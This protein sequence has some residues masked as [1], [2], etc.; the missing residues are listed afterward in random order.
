M[1]T[2]PEPGSRHTHSRSPGIALAPDGLRAG[3]PPIL[4]C[5]LHNYSMCNLPALFLELGRMGLQHNGPAPYCFSTVLCSL[6]RRVGSIW[7]KWEIRI[8]HLCYTDSL[9]QMDS[10]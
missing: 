8:Y 7:Q 10:D 5:P 1:V 4:A 6:S 2:A 3:P 9:L